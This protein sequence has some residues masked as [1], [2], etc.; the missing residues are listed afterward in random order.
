M[1]K[2]AQGMIVSASAS[3]RAKSSALHYSEKLTAAFAANAFLRSLMPM[4]L[5][6]AGSVISHA[7]NSL[8]GIS[9]VR[10]LI[11][12]P[13]IYLTPALGRWTQFTAASCA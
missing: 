7:V 11:I 5:T 1:G 12:R 4:V 2:R 6:T 10:S 8:L 13:S 9:L 3:L